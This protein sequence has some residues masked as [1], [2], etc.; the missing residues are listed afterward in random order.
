MII[1][2]L[3]DSEE[4]NSQSVRNKHKKRIKKNS[5]IHKTCRLK[6]K[7]KGSCFHQNAIYCSSKEE[8]KNRYKREH[9]TKERLMQEELSNI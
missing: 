2:N 8:K 6:P 4:K 7:H 9:I 1:K 3:H 5:F